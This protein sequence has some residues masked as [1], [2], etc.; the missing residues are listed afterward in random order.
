MVNFVIAQI[1]G[2]I[3]LIVLIISFQK[4]EKK[5]LLK[6]QIFSS[7]LYAIQYAF[8]GPEAYVGCLMNLTCMFR[9][10][11]FNKYQEKRPPLYWLIIVIILMITFSL[12][13]FKGLISLLPMLAVVL[14]S[15]VVWNGN[16]KKVRIVE[17][18]SCLL[19]IIYN[20]RVQ[21]YAGLVATIIEMLGAMVALYKFNIKKSNKITE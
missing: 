12:L 4:N 17:I 19:Y 15:I 7:L 18:I 21:A 6:Y 14:Y 13:T 11:I 5:K 2:S 8:L 20:I 16:L 10:F 9:N 3:A 1:F